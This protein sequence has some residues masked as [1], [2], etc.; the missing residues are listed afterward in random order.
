MVG[1]TTNSTR[2]MRTVTN[3]LVPIGELRDSSI[4]LFARRSVLVV[5]TLGVLAC[6]SNYALADDTAASVA[7]PPARPEIIAYN[8]FWYVLYFVGAIWLFAGYALLIRMRFGPRLRDSLERKYPRR[9][10]IRQAL[11]FAAL[12]FVLMLWNLPLGAIGFSH[13]KAYGFAT[14]SVWLWM[15]DHG[16]ALLLGMLT[17]PAVWVGYWL[18]RRSPKRW[19]LWLWAASVPW[20]FGMF[21]LTPVVIAPLYNDF[22]PLQD[23]VLRD[24]LLALAERAGVKGA[25]VYQVDKSTRTTKLNAYVAGIGPTKRIVICDTTLKALTQDEIVAIMAHEMGHYVLGHVWIRLG[26]NIVGAFVLLWLL[27]RLYPW[28]IQRWGE[29]IGVKHIL[30]L[31]GLPVFLMILQMML[32]LQTPIESALSRRDERAADR[33]GLEMNGDGAA[34][35]RAYVAFVRKDFADPDPPA[36]IVFW[37]YSHPPLRER[38][39]MALAHRR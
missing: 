37:F 7:L 4:P 11:F 21:I 30:D 26:E 22:R 2:N 24:R 5:F 19:W 38:V 9:L 8:R 28:A 25:Q 17:I 10:W 33:F 29:R 12:S 16:R 18:I 27:S 23:P 39:E 6:L 31:G 1:L 13:E 36:F 3:N 34:M 32:F 20:Q 35:A 15:A 14:Q